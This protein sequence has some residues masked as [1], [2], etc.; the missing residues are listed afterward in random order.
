MQEDILG[1]GGLLLLDKRES[2]HYYEILRDAGCW[3]GREVWE[4]E[5]RGGSDLYRE[6]CRDSEEGGC[7]IS[8]GALRE[9]ASGRGVEEERETEGALELTVTPGER[10]H[11]P[12]V[13]K[14]GYVGYHRTSVQPLKS[15]V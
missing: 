2:L 12:T 15:R 14:G 11:E 7:L 5:R 8:E 1:R 4:G 10:Y 3:E 6:G 9:A 13:E